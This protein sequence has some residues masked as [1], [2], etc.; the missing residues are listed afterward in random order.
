MPAALADYLRALGFDAAKV[1]E[2]G[3]SGAV[4]ADVLAAAA[5]EERVLLTFDVGFADIRRY[6]LGSHAGIVVFRLRDQ[7]WQVLQQ[8]LKRLLANPA[9]WQALSR[10][11]AIVD[12][13]RVRYRPGKQPRKR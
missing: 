1:D 11:L 12:D 5:R 8:G 4:D 7:R 2:E 10:G 6:P 13:A 9:K 3:L